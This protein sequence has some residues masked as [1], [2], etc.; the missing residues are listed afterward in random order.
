M[1]RTNF[2]CSTCGSNEDV[3]VFRFPKYQE[4]LCVE[5]RALAKDPNIWNHIQTIFEAGYRAGVRAGRDSP[6]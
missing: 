6:Y 1:A 3:Q 5:C 2:D 4:W